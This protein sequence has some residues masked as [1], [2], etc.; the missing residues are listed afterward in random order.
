MFVFMFNTLFRGVS[1]ILDNLCKPC[2]AFGCKHQVQSLSGNLNDCPSFMDIWID[3]RTHHLFI[4][5]EFCTIKVH[6]K[7][8]RVSSLS[9]RDDS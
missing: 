8:S 2:F 1:D 5:E 7:V 6:R 3:E 4:I 9:K